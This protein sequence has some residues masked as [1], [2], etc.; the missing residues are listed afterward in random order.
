M[1]GQARRA[2]RESGARPLVTIRSMAGPFVF[3]AFASCSLREPLA[4]VQLQAEVRAKKSA[5]KSGYAVALRSSCLAGGV[6]V[7]GWA[8]GTAAIFPRALRVPVLR[9]SVPRPRPSTPPHSPRPP[10]HPS[11]LDAHGQAR[12]R[13]DGLA[14]SRP[15]PIVL[16][17]SVPS[18]SPFLT[19]KRVPDSRRLG[20]GSR[21]SDDAPEGGI[22]RNQMWLSAGERR[23]GR[24]LP[25][26]RPM[27]TAGS[28]PVPAIHG[29]PQ[30]NSR[31]VTTS[32]QES[33]VSSEAGAG[34]NYTPSLAY[35]GRLYEIV[36][37]CSG[38]ALFLPSHARS[39]LP[40]RPPRG[41]PEIGLI[42]ALRA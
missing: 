16:R 29:R 37:G 22:W 12:F 9:L 32:R 27:R 35:W 3:M 25:S 7:V 40:R 28:S 18:S 34:E 23:V 24:L 20:L 38:S 39:P 17:S 36:T 4:R 11:A 13:I 15:R 5:K 14:R 31:G 10:I 2:V 26:P 1:P 41:L 19:V 42:A 33:R 8:P 6:A 21:Y 30:T